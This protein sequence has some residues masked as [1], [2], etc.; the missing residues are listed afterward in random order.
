MRRAGWVVG[1][2]G[3]RAEIARQLLAGETTFRHSQNDWDWLGDGA[4]FWEGDA[5]RALQFVRKYQKNQ[6]YAVVGAYL[7][8]GHCLDL[9]TQDGLD[10][11]RV[12]HDALLKIY[13]ARGQVLPSNT[14]KLRY[15]DRIVINAARELA[16]VDT[17]MPNAVPR[18]KIDSVRGAF[19][20]AGEAYPGAKFTALN[21]IQIAIINPQCIRGLFRPETG[22][23]RTD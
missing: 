13:T 20:E 12:S 18:P 7:D 19:P 15:L 2:H 10:L 11:A 5:R 4:Y 21:H 1:F 3:C 8:L 14:E 6:E 9:T 16:E 23:W 22:G 17:S